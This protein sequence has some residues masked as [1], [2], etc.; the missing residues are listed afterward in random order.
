MDE[1]IEEMADEID[2]TIPNGA[3][4][5]RAMVGVVDNAGYLTGIRLA[6]SSSKRDLLEGEITP[7]R[8]EQHIEEELDAVYTLVGAPSDEE[9]VRENI[10]TRFLDAASRALADFLSVVLSRSV[11]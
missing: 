11:G 3:N 6:T 8:L 7:E 10:K 2:K 9:E 1:T 5:T 4:T